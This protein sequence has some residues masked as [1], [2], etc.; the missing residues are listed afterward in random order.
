[1]AS[2]VPTQE[3]A[4]DPFASYNSNTVNRLTRM[5]TRG[6]DGLANYNSLQVTS[7]STSPLSAVVLSDGVIFKDDVLLTMTADHTVDFYDSQHYFNTGTGVFNEAGI[8]YI[9]LE[10]TYAKSRPAPD[11]M[12]KILKPSQRSS[13]S[14][15]SLF[16]LKAVEV[17]FNGSTFEIDSTGFYDYDPEDTSVRREYVSWYMSVETALPTFEAS[18]D[19]GRMVYDSVTDDVWF[20]LKDQWLQVP[21][22]ILK[23]TG[24]ITTWTS[25]SG[26]YRHDVDISSM[27]ATDVVLT[28][29][30]ADNGGIMEKIEPANVQLLTSG[31]TYVTVRV[32]MT[33]NTINVLYN[34]SK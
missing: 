1:M 22:G 14:G 10:Y 34:I 2:S 27:E 28:S 13:I 15:P 17:I 24:T 11:A 29:F 18:R 8:Y 23:L 26:L 12:A 32:W 20:G 31:S 4:V 3:R 9:V 25:D 7:D 30:Y 21:I 6:I 19:T 5:I 33:V 16:F